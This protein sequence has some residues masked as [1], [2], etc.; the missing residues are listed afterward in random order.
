MAAHGNASIADSRQTLKLRGGT[1]TLLVVQVVDL[2][3]PDFFALLAEKIAQAPAFFQ[4]AP[5][6][7]DLQGLSDSGPFHFVELVEGLSQHQLTPVGV[8]NGTDEQNH[9]AAEAGLSVFPVWRSSTPIEDPAE[10][11]APAAKQPPDEGVK[12][13]IVTRPIRSGNEVYARG[14]DLVVMTTVSPG[15]ELLADGH[16]HIYGRLRG[17]A[18][19]GVTG[20]TSSR[21]FCQT[22]DAE[23]V[24]VAGHWRVREDMGEELIGKPV[25]IFLQGEQ[26]VIEPLS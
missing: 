16:V 6:V 1:F 20:D 5:V 7:L 15:A 3:D 21:I 9:A 2:R 18:H 4:H 17:R 22:L 19:A 24:S 12:S 26:L 10:Q 13:T 14:G 23:L 11:K 8:Q 25:Q